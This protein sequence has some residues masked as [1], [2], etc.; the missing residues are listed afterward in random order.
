[1]QARGTTVRS[2]HPGLTR[3]DF[4]IAERDSNLPWYTTWSRGYPSLTFVIGWTGYVVAEDLVFFTF[5][6]GS[7]YCQHPQHTYLADD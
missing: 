5:S 1:M 6:F 4:I 2:L 7:M 3:R